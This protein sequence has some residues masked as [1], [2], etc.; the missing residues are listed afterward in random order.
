MCSSTRLHKWQET[1]LRIGVHTHRLL[2]REGKGLVIQLT[3]MS[4]YD[5]MPVCGSSTASMYVS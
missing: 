2:S 4:S 5:I 1:R 3:A